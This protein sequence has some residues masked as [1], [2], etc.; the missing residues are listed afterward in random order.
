MKFVTILGNKKETYL[1]VQKNTGKTKQFLS[2]LFKREQLHY[3]IS[4]T[5][6]YI[7]KEAKGK[8]T[9]VPYNLLHHIGKMSRNMFGIKTK[10]SLCLKGDS[11]H[12]ITVQ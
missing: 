6:L 1:Q 11:K 2:V 4:Q 7:N 3:F 12:A 5:L 9:Y 10:P 8:E